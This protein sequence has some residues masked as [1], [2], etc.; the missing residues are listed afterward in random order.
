MPWLRIGKEKCG[1]HSPKSAVLFH[2]SLPVA[3]KSTIKFYWSTSNGWNILNLTS[4]STLN[5]L[6]ESPRRGREDYRSRPGDLSSECYEQE[7]LTVQWQPSSLRYQNC[8][9]L[10]VTLVRFTSNLSKTPNLTL[11]SAFWS[12]SRCNSINKFLKDLTSQAGL[13]TT[14]KNFTNHSMRKPESQLANKGNSANK[15]AT[16]QQVIQAAHMHST[17]LTH[18]TITLILLII[19]HTHGHQCMLLIITKRDLHSPKRI[20]STVILSILARNRSTERDPF[21]VVL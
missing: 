17:P 13:Q 10:F 4:Q 14:Q 6:K 1:L 3:G 11:G 16:Q 15:L 7:K 18:H 20:S 8:L 9:Q 5:G 12:A 19:T 21:M 2:V